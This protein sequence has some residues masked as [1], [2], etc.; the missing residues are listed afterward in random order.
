MGGG[1]CS[2]RATRVLEQERARNQFLRC[3]AKP[4]GFVLECVSFM[5]MCMYVIVGGTHLCTCV[6][7]GGWCHISSFCVLF[8][9]A[10]SLTETGASQSNSLASQLVLVDLSP[11][12]YWD[13][14]QPLCQ[15]VIYVGAEHLISDPH[16]YAASLLS[17]E[18]AQS[19]FIDP[20]ILM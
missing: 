7:A 18:P 12:K 10:V 13:T 19:C 14:R 4:S 8:T 15:L 9:D 2:Y 20:D 3:N 17:T 5:F 11:P 1:L 6:Q 16:V